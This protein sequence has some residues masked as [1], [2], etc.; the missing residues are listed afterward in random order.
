MG[1]HPAD[2]LIGAL[3]RRSGVHIETI[4]YYERIGLMPAPPRSHGGHR[5]YDRD[6]LKR[7][8]FIHRSRRLGFSIQ[9]IRDLLGLVEGDYTC[10]DVKT[11]VL[12]HLEDIRA[13]I[14]DLKKLESTL[15]EFADLCDG[16]EAVACPIINQLFDV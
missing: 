3:S 12:D 16:G 2:L 1:D 9:E 14:A 5:V 15:L 8:S 10:G 11:V 13:K 4:R 6:H 7:L